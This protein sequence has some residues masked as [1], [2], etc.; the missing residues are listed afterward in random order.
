MWRYE[1]PTSERFHF[2]NRIGG[3]DDPQEIEPVRVKLGSSGRHR[4]QAGSSVIVGRQQDMLKA[5]V[6]R[7]VK[8]LIAEYSRAAARQI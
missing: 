7:Q 1:H 6:A 3:T 5:V 2:G 4:F 8:N